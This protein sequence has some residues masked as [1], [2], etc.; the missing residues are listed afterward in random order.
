[1]NSK[2]HAVTYEAQKN[3]NSL[4]MK[5]PIFE[6]HGFDYDKGNCSTASFFSGDAKSDSADSRSSKR[7]YDEKS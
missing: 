2:V 4:K 5:D 7:V 6:T 1:L 3:R